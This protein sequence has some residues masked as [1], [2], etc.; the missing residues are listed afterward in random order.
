MKK[1]ETQKEVV[2]K[3]LQ[4][5]QGMEANF[6]TTKAF[7]EEDILELK[8]IVSLLAHSERV[9]LQKISQI[10]DHLHTDMSLRFF[11]NML[12][13]LERALDR[14]LRDDQF[15][16]LS[17]DRPTNSGPRVPLI[18]LLE[19][20]RSAFNVGSIFRLAD[21]LNAQEI[22]LVGYTLTPDSEQL[23]KTSL[24]ATGN[25]PWKH[26]AKTKD[27]VEELKQKNFE[28]IGLETAQ[29]SESL[30]SA[31]LSKPTAFLVGNERF[32]LEVPSLELCDRVISIPTFGMKN[33]LNVSQA[34]SIA[35]YEWRR[36]DSQNSSE[37]A[38]W[39]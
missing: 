29:N 31:K 2:Q 16:I 18:F 17:E 21:C 22:Y 34:L 35:S 25:I 19:N 3:A 30:F 6:L 24:G 13:P 9:D 38:S 5:M 27:A 39:K 7:T 26:F 20:L 12:V 37:A 36:Q 4:K 23:K 11:V 28:I 8:G 10:P 32:G 15:L 33:S 14:N 1:L